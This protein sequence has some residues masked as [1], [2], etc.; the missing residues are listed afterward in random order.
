M[1]KLAEWLK[2]NLL[3]LIVIGT[4]FLAI[5]QI[6]NGTAVIMSAARRFKAFVVS[7]IL[8][9]LG[10][11]KYIDNKL[12]EKVKHLEV[13]IQG[14]NELLRQVL[15]SVTPVNGK[16]WDEYLHG[17]SDCNMILEQK[18]WFLRA[19]PFSPKSDEC[20][21]IFEC[22]TEANFLRVDSRFT[23]VTGLEEDQVIGRG[24]VNAVHYKDRERV[25]A[26]LHS[27]LEENREFDAQFTL[28][29]TSGEM[30]PVHCRTRKLVNSHGALARLLGS[31]QILECN[32]L[33]CAYSQCIK[34]RV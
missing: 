22:D 19:W 10:V 23:T 20:L 4:V 29:S 17:I 13:A 25:M 15:Q 31:I 9:L 21:C 8:Y 6:A 1:N 34:H 12:S 11:E 28:Y 33:K 26:E 5:T 16:S 27:A 14:T 7:R 32:P 30:L 3:W 2:E 24:W 18:Q